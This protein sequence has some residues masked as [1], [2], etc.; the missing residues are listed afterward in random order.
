MGTLIIIL[1]LITIITYFIVLH[2]EK[3]WLT[4]W[5]KSEEKIIDNTKSEYYR[6]NGFHEYDT[7]ADYVTEF[8]YY[9][10]QRHTSGKLR[11]KL[12]GNPSNEIITE[13]NQIIGELEKKLHLN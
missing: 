4:I 1:V 3:Q 5:L 13:G 7:I 6:R 10:I 2:K 11:I 8:N 12:K 9:M